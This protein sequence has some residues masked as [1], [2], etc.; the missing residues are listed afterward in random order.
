MWRMFGKSGMKIVASEFGDTYIF[1]AA[2]EELRR[3]WREIGTID[4][5]EKIGK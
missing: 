5:E 1:K 3:R 2:E 4:R